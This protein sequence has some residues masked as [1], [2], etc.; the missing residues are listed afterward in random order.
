MTFKIV[1]KSPDDA[2][3]VITISLRGNVGGGPDEDQFLRYI[4]DLVDGEDG[5]TAQHVVLDL[6]KVRFMSAC[7]LGMLISAQTKLRN[8]GGDL[9]LARI[10]DRMQSFLI[11]TRLITVFRC[12]GTLEQAR[13]SFTA[14][15]EPTHV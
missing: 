10:T 9:R 8:A 2:S 14:E 11:I 4:E 7:G 6:S 3:D 5:P 13:G 12:Y 15:P 1:A